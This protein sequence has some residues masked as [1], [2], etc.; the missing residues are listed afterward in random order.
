MTCGPLCP[1]L[2]PLCVLKC[3]SAR[4]E[5]SQLPLGHALESTN[6]LGDSGAQSGRNK[7]SVDEGLCRGR[8]SGW[9]MKMGRHSPGSQGEKI[10][11]N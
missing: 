3:P 5:N 6:G 7:Q 1:G 8:G 11:Q 9:L 10:S 4:D 2:L